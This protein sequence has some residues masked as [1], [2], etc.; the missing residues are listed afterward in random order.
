[1]TEQI[2]RQC[3]LRQGRTFQVVWIPAHL[4]KVGKNVRIR[5][6]YKDWLVLEAWKTAPEHLLSFNERDHRAEFGSLA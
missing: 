3:K 4:A 1:M 6:E 2:Y 5:G